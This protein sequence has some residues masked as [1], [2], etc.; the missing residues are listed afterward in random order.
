MKTLTAILLLVLLFLQYKLWFS[1]GGLLKVQQLERAIAVQEDENAALR[2]RNAALAA[3]VRDLKQGHAAIQERARTELGMVK[4][5]E[6]F[7]QVVNPR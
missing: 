7:F 1:D 5:G 4:E 2:E 6:T 3:E